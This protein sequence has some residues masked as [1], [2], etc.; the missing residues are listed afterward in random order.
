MGRTDRE[1]CRQNLGE[2]AALLGA[3]DAL[4]PRDPCEGRAWGGRVSEGDGEE[5]ACRTLGGGFARD[6]SERP[7]PRAP[8]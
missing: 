8:P 3:A 1:A 4:L 2:V 6:R 7:H 5:Q